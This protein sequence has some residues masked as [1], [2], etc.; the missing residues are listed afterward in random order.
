MTKAP[1]CK[2]CGHNH[3][4]SESHTYV[5]VGLS[6][7]ATDAPPVTKPVAY[8]PTEAEMITAAVTTH[9]ECPICGHLHRRPLTGAQRAKDWRERNKQLQKRLR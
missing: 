5:L 6:T 9:H 4:L 1:R 7:A 3:W 8:I 2:L